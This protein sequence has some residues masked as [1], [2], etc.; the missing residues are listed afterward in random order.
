M[1]LL[2]YINDELCHKDPAE[3]RISVFT[4][5][6][7]ST[8]NWSNDTQENFTFKS[9]E[10]FVLGE[11]GRKK[12]F[13]GTFPPNH[14]SSFSVSLKLVRTMVCRVSSVER[15]LVR[16]S[17]FSLESNRDLALCRSVVLLFVADLRDLELFTSKPHLAEQRSNAGR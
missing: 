5:G 10:N 16:S 12:R 15:Q 17:S 11:R 9:W 14:F 2:I 3:I 1:I 7:N 8:R 13:V 6:L 4:K